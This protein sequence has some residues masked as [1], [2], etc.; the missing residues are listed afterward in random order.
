MGAGGGGG[1]RV[2]YY[3]GRLHPTVPLSSFDVPHG[4]KSG[5]FEH[6]YKQRSKVCHTSTLAL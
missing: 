3:S 2:G 5:V 6:P 4:F 1:G